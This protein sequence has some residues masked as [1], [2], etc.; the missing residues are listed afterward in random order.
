[1]TSYLLQLMYNYYY[2]YLRPQMLLFCQLMTICLELLL[3]KLSPSHCHL[4]VKSIAV[5]AVRTTE[6]LLL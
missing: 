4:S 6:S 3:A 1:M 2:Y 5:A